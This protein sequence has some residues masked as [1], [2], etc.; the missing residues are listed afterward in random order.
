M[1][2]RRENFSNFQNSNSEFAGR[3]G[4][5]RW[6]AQQQI[7]VQSEGGTGSRVGKSAGDNKSGSRDS[8][9][10][11]KDSQAERNITDKQSQRVFEHWFLLENEMVDAIRKGNSKLIRTALV[12]VDYLLK[13][14]PPPL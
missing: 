13:V 6:L 7:G 4:D 5:E 8:K 14:P 2:A 11:Q 1:R 10:A 3:R 9:V 12:R